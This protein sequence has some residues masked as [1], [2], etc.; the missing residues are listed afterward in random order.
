MGNYSQ[1][2]IMMPV[3]EG[4]AR[5]VKPTYLL[6]EDAKFTFSDAA[7]I[8]AYGGNLFCESISTENAARAVDCWNGC[9]GIVNPA[10]VRDVVEA[11]V[12]VRDADNDVKSDGGQGIPFAARAKIDSALAALKGGVS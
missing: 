7:N 5:A 9:I 4:H 2:K 10:A 3:S 12:M 6:A 8:K 1:G 11:L